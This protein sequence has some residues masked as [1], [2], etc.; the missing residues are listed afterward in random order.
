MS[1]H[2]TTDDLRAVALSFRL[3][4]RTMYLCS[5]P[6]RMA[7]M[8]ALVTLRRR[9]PSMGFLQAERTTQR[10]LRIAHRHGEAW[11]YGA[12]AADPWARPCDCG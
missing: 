10:L 7:R 11:L 3:A 9:H 4:Y 8:N 5:D 2:L 6:E 1:V 12:F